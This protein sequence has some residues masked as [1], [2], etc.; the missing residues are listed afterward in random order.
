MLFQYGVE[1]YFEE[2]K[3]TRSNSISII[4]AEVLFVKGRKSDELLRSEGVKPAESI[5]T[6]GGFVN[7]AV[8]DL[9]GASMKV[10]KVEKSI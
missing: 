3:W 1:R 4:I 8:N 2:C 10:I 5:K 9:R 7:G 6:N